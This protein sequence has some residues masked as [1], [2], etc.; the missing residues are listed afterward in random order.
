[1]STA[2]PSP[3]GIPS[4]VAAPGSRS[5]CCTNCSGAEPG[6][7]SPR[8]ASVEA[9]VRLECLNARSSDVT[10]ASL[11]NRL[12]GGDTMA[13]LTALVVVLTLVTI[14]GFGLGSPGARA[15]APQ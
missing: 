2:A 4:G 5:L 3:W 6:T 8:C 10:Y 7:A 11:R 12:K 1:M 14:G 9:W 13:R 15:Q